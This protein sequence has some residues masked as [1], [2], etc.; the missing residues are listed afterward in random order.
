MGSTTYEVDR[1]SHCRTF[2]SPPR[3]AGQLMMCGSSPRPKPCCQCCPEKEDK[4]ISCVLF[5]A[6]S[7]WPHILMTRED[8]LKSDTT[9][10]PQCTRSLWRWVF[11]CVLNVIYLWNAN[12]ANTLRGLLCSQCG[13]WWWW[14][15]WTERRSQ[16][17]PGHC[18]R[19][20]GDKEVVWTIR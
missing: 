16:S 8:E 10:P 9:S 15:W 18:W 2:P 17:Q 1:E 20:W 11:L 19:R 4:W 5:V 6:F 12:S 13:R 3:A 7:G 14:W